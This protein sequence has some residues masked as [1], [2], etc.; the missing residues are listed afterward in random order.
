MSNHSEDRPLHS[1]RGASGAH[2]WMNCAGSIQLIESLVKKYG[3]DVILKTTEPAAEGTVA[4]EVGAA[5]LENNVEAWEY[6]GEERE[7]EGWK[8]TVDEGMIDAVQQYVDFVNSKV[9]QHAGPDT[10]LHIEFGMSS[11]LDPDAYGT[12]DVTI[13]VPG[14]RIII[15]DYKHGLGVVVEPTEAQLSYY[16]YLAYENRP[17][18]MRGDGEPKVIELWIAQPRI[19]HPNGPFRQS[20][21]SPDRL[22]FWFEENV[23]PAME[24]TREPDAPLTLGDWCQFCDAKPYCPA[25]RHEATTFL[26]YDEVEVL[27]GEEIGSLLARGKIIVKFISD[28]EPEA[29]RRLLNNEK[30]PGF[31]LVNKKSKR[32]WLTGAETEMKKAY[33]DDAYTDPKLLGPTG[34]DKLMKGKAFSKKWSHQPDLGLTMAPE[35]DKRTEVVNLMDSDPVGSEL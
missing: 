31:K 15:V 18:S 34:V 19:P 12:S 16:G 20:V 30:V 27:T 13:Y 21:E 14:D 10:I 5:C 32:I 2:C 3:R 8:F 22:T 28:L 29:Y 7:V 35:S 26:V 11:K 4:H 6:G 1:P 17:D 9:K 24:R 23:I 33:G 25:M